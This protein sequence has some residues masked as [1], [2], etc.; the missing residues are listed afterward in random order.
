MNEKQRLIFDAVKDYFGEV[1]SKEKS[2][3]KNIA[4]YLMGKRKGIKLSD[5]EKSIVDR[6][7]AN[8]ND[9]IYLESLSRKAL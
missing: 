6:I 9:K 3:L 5:E 1:S 4:L 8:L 2:S 7:K